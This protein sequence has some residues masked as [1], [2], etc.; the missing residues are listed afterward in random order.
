MQYVHTR[1]TH[2]HILVALERRVTSDQY[3]ILLTDQ[4]Y[5]VRKPFLPDGSGLFQGD[6]APSIHFI[7]KDGC[8]TPFIHV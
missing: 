4:L 3:N 8:D 6:P 1:I 2:V 5:P 7:L